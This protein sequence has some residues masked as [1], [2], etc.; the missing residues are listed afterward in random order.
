MP[1]TI[2]LTRAYF[3]VWNKH[4]EAGIKAKHAAASTLQD[5]AA[6]FGPTNADVSA[7]IAGIWKS[8]PAIKIEI[9]DVYTCG[10]ALSCVANI[11]VVVDAATTLK[12]CDVITYDSA[13][14]VVSLV[15]YKAD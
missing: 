3:E 7:G 6:K 8:N 12:V 10:E 14:L 2:A 15:A 4:D 11:K 1:D 9:I 13:G 5:W